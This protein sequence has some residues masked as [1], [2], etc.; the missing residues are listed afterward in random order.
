MSCQNSVE[1]EN[2]QKD[3]IVVLGCEQLKSRVM[4]HLYHGGKC[5]LVFSFPSYA[6]G[7]ISNPESLDHSISLRGCGSVYHPMNESGRTT[8]AEVRLLPSSSSNSGYQKICMN[9]HSV[10]RDLALILGCSK[11]FHWGALGSGRRT[12]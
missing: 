11:E 6:A 7:G 12:P 5:L 2:L 9:R 1:R 4:C 8:S 3:G 10:D